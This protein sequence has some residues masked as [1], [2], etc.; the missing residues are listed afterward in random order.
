MRG[1]EGAGRPLPRPP[2]PPRPRDSHSRLQSRR[3]SPGSGEPK[4]VVRV[5][6]WPPPMS[7]LYWRNVGGAARRSRGGSG[8]DGPLLT[9]SAWINSW[10]RAAVIRPDATWS[11]GRAGGES[12]GEGEGE[13]GGRGGWRCGWRGRVEGRME[14]RTRL[15]L[16]I[17]LW[18]SATGSIETTCSSSESSESA[19][20]AAPKGP[21]ALPRPPSPASPLSTSEQPCNGANAA[22][23]WWIRG[24]A[25]FRVEPGVGVLRVAN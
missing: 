9:A 10:Y 12:E 25:R 5:A 15:R 7:R 17:F 11:K 6:L 21:A 8:R 1:A 22:P 19:A 24:R 4:L 2:R 23:T 14:G 13:G 20:P 3:L 18:V 16:R